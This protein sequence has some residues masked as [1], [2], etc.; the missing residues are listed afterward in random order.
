LRFSLFLKHPGG[1][2]VAVIKDVERECAGLDVRL[3]L[4]SQLAWRPI[5]VITHGPYVVHER[6]GSFRFIRPTALPGGRHDRSWHHRQSDPLEA[7]ARCLIGVI[8]ERRS[9]MI[10]SGTTLRLTAPTRLT[11]PM[12][13]RRNIERRSCQCV[14]NRDSVQL[15]PAKRRQAMSFIR[16]NR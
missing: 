9:R 7:D 13:A 10:Y 16:S 1:A 8:I 11:S 6:R 5:S 15:L 4:G 2:P 12:S 14:P 3:F